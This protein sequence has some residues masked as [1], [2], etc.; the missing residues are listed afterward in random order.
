MVAML[1]GA[2]GTQDWCDCVDLTMHNSH[3]SMQLVPV[4][5]ESIRINHPLPF[6][7][8]DKNGVLLAKRSFVID[9]KEDLADI[10]QRGGGLYID[11]SDSEA[12]HRAYV[13]RLHNLVRTGKSLGEIAEAKITSDLSANRDT[14]DDERPDWLDLQIQAN[15]LLRD[16]Q[17][18]HF[19]ERLDRVYSQLSRHSR[20]NPDGTLFALIQLSATEVRM[21]SATHAMLVSVMCGLA[22]R[23]VL[24]WS[25]EQETSLCRAALTMNLSMT[26]LQDQ[27]TRQIEAPSPVQRKA[28]DT[29]A[30]KSAEILKE[31]GVTDTVWLD[32]VRDHHTQTPGPL[33]NR[34]P[35]QQVARLIQRADMF[36]AR[37]APRASRV[38]IS[39]AAAMQACYFDE[40]RQVD[41]A[42]AALIKAVGIYQPGSFVRLA[43]D[44]VAVVIK[45]GMNTSTPRVAVLINR[46]GMPTIEPTI[47]ETSTRDYRI[48]ASVPH[49]EVKVQ[50]N[51]D[52]LLPLTATP[53]SDRPW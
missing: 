43:T 14:Q 33:Q 2:G 6:P 25:A 29:H 35:A 16:S 41:E 36:A 44:E 37:L 48:V 13:G 49:R 17:P 18:A 12:H 32:A 8:M 31:M 51:L 9:S 50:I 4:S 19:M 47:R 5:V 21:Y 27:L 11:A 52:R 40:N 23:E 7:L 53:T 24:K 38:P 3:S 46:T 22:A 45:R 20:R 1:A 26:S 34:T 10:A 28:I 39:P 42:G 15:G 30:A